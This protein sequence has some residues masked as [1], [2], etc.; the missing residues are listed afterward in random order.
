MKILKRTEFQHKQ[1]SSQ[2]T[3]EVFSH[4]VVL[5]ELLGMQDIFVHHDVIAPGHR[6]SSPHYHAEVEEF[7]F[8]IKGTATIHEGDEASFAKP[9]DCVVFLPQNENKHFVANDSNE[10]LEILVVSKSLNTVD[11]VY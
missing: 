8:I 1:L 11:V 5:S 3:G 9:G 10:D 2:R 7:V 6:A 4:S